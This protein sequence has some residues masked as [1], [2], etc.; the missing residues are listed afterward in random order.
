MKSSTF[1]WAAAFAAMAVVACESKTD[2]PTGP[3][4]ADVVTAVGRLTD[5][6]LATVTITE[7]VGTKRECVVWDKDGQGRRICITYM[8]VPVERKTQKDAYVSVAATQ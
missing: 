4:S 6:A 3:V 2:G 7:L 8:D 1:G 5:R